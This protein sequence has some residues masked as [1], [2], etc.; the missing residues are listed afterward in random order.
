MNI[1]DY[2]TYMRLFNNTRKI[3]CYPTLIVYLKVKDVGVLIERIKMR[4]RK[5]EAGIKKDYLELLNK[6]YNEFF[7]NYMGPKIVID[8]EWDMDE[9][10]FFMKITRRIVETIRDLKDLESV[11]PLGIY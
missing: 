8:A 3:I 1:T 7:D 2:E 11:I 10:D 4:D 9:K 6:T 5:A